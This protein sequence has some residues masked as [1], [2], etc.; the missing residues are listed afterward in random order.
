[1]IGA[2]R[3]DEYVAAVAHDEI[4]SCIGIEGLSSVRKTPVSAEVGNRSCAKV[5]IDRETTMRLKNLPVTFGPLKEPPTI[6]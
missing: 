2:L 6:G 4:V 3:S 5:Q 1:L